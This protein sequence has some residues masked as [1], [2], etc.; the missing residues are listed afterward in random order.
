M[1]E[2]TL[3]QYDTCAAWR[4]CFFAALVCVVFLYRNLVCVLVFASD[5]AC[6]CCSSSV[7][8]AGQCWCSCWFSA[9]DVRSWLIRDP[10]RSFACRNCF[11]L[12]FLPWIVFDLLF[13]P[14]HAVLQLSVIDACS[15]FRGYLVRL[16]LCVRLGSHLCVFCK[17]AFA[18]SLCARFVCFGPYSSTNA[19]V[20]VFVVGCVVFCRP[21]PVDHDFLFTLLCAIVLA[22]D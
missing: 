8:E 5:R 20:C 11:V 13:V 7:Y 22:F 15:C 19:I 2:A 21:T 14:Q 12:S 3:Q 6:Y 1:R 9:C 18:S 10:H 4:V 17:S 16:Q